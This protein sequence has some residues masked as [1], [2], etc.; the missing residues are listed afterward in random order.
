MKK[1]LNIACGVNYINDESWIN[2]DFNTYGPN[3][4]KYNILNKLPF[5]D[6]EFDLIYSSHF[7]EHIP[8]NKLEN[9]FKECLRVLKMNGY[10]RIVTPDFEEMCKSYL[11]FLEK[12]ETKKKNFLMIEIMDQLVRKKKGGVLRD[13]INY[14][15]KNNDKE[16]KKFIELRTGYNFKIDT[17]YKK[18]FLEKI[19]KKIVD[20]Y[21]D[22]LVKLFPRSFAEQNISLTEIGENHTWLW[23]YD[24]L[25][26]ILIK[27]GFSNINKKNFN[28]TDIS[29][30]NLNYL[31]VRKNNLPRKG[32]ESMYIEAKKIN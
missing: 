30:L 7:I 2:I 23:D 9:F 25:R 5:K 14:A 3:V 8:L 18:N 11:F 28:E 16:M 17:R 31:D 29:F 19:K 13:S 20:I 22:F 15:F 32:K 4:K 27:Y 26:E 6:Q 12:K 24:S 21:I 1:K 10:I